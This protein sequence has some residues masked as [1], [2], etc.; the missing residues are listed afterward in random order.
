MSGKEARSF[1]VSEREANAGIAPYRDTQS[2]A[3]AFARFVINY[4]VPN[5]RTEFERFFEQNK[6]PA[7]IQTA[8]SFIK[9]GTGTSGC[10]NVHTF[11]CGLKSEE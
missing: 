2:V 1:S 11:R 5:F 9:F 3:A 4:I 7:I 10:S 6:R 8:A